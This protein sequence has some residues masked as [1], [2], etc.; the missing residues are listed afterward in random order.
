MNNISSC[1]CTF[2]LYLND[3]KYVCVYVYIHCDEINDLLLLLLL[4]TF[5]Q[6]FTTNLYAH[7]GKFYFVY[8]KSF[9]KQAV[10]VTYSRGSLYR[11]SSFWIKFLHMRANYFV[12]FIVHQKTLLH[13]I[14]V[15]VKN[16]CLTG[17][18]SYRL[19]VRFQRCS[20]FHQTSP[21]FFPPFS[22][23]FALKGILQCKNYRVSSGNVE[24]LYFKTVMS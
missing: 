4:T 24:L 20:S 16:K 9:Q 17:S 19:P 15:V 21:T 1:W 22:N 8:F 18:G 2:L 3:L 6:N 13:Q 5:V 12:A 10:H 7:S 14:W 23:R 11:A